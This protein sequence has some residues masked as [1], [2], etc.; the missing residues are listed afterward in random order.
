MNK[1]KLFFIYIERTLY[2]L[3]QKFFFNKKNRNP[4]NVKNILVV[5]LNHIGDL[6]I[7]L[8]SVF[9]LKEK[10]KDAKITLVTGI[11]NKGLVEFQ[12][13]L[14]DNVYYYNL[15]KNCRN[16]NLKMSLPRK[17]GILKKLRKEKYELCADFDGAWIFCFLYIFSKIKYLSTAAY[18]RFNQNLEQLKIKK[19]K[20]KYD[21]NRSYEGDN[22]FEVVKQFSVPDNREKFVLNIDNEIKNKA[23]SFINGLG[24]ERK[25]VGIHPVASIKEK[26]WTPEGFAHLCNHLL[27][28]KNFSVVIFGAKDDASYIKEIA[29]KIEYKENVNIQ[30][31]FN[32]GEFI[33]A[34]SYC[35]CFICLDSLAQH[36]VRYFNLPSLIIYM[37][38]NS[39]RWSKAGDNI[40]TVLLKNK[41]DYNNIF[42]ELTYFNRI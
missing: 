20:F 28:E 38:E 26:M 22:I 18:L 25:I 42:K 36:I 4:E 10:F 3:L 23:N 27:S 37:S 41:T 19:N 30:T 40:K 5:R 14:F 33:T 9:C 16:K 1:L 24:R 13:Q 31:A 2:F 7:S 29:D 11:W 21:I 39:A 15:N 35:D 8:P 6:F 34:V 17:M 32:I 12:S